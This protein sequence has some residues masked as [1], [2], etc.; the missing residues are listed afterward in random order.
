[1]KIVEVNSTVTVN[2]TGKLHDG[3]VFDSSL[4]EGRE[5]LSATLG[6]GALISG[7]EKGLLGMKEGDRKT[8]EIPS[9]E[10]YG[11]VR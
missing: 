9:E 11:M 1:M 2:Y 4:T 3:S 7:F 8:I 10:A 6:Q 5:P